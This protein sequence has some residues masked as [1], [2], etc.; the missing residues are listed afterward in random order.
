M[1]FLPK[2]GHTYVSHSFCNT[3]PV[4]F[5]CFVCIPAPQVACVLP[6]SASLHVHFCVHFHAHATFHPSPPLQPSSLIPD[7]LL[8]T[9]Q[10]HLPAA[11]SALATSS[12]PRGQVSAV[13]GSGWEQ[14]GMQGV[15]GFLSALCSGWGYLNRL[16]RQCCR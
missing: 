2:P 16:R 7:C 12:P 8:H 10:C 4:P 13:K 1:L 5:S 15:E 6:A 9:L 3:C 11:I 14:C